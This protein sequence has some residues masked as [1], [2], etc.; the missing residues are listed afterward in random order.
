MP[1]VAHE[2]L[3]VVLQ[4]RHGSLHV[5]L[6][7]HGRGPASGAWA[8]PGGPLS[9]HETLGRSIARQLA[10]KVDVRDMR[11]PGTARDA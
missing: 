6:W 5:L 4:V 9:G 10:E 1:S 2:V 8:L 7:R 11:P 3:A